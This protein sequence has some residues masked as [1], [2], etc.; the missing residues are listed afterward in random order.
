MKA[1]AK[2]REL[3]NHI[4]SGVRDQNYALVPFPLSRGDFNRGVSH[5]FEFLSL[6]DDVKNQFQSNIIE[7]DEESFVGYIKREKQKRVDEALGEYFYDQKEYFH[8]NRYAEEYFR[9]FLNRGNERITT[10]FESARLIY[11][12]AEGVAKQIINDFNEEFP[13]LREKFTPEGAHPHFYL[14]FL[15]YYTSGKGS[16]LA[17]AHYDQGGYTLAL[18][19]S[20]PGLRIGK[21]EEGLKEVEHTDRHAVFMPGLQLRFFTS[22]EFTPA[23]H[24]VVQKGDDMYNM[25]TARWAVVFFVD[26]VE[27][28]RTRWEDR[29]KAMN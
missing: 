6:P 22:D 16:F 11:E 25:E 27:K 29:H 26:P 28:I 19:E 17:K 14:R 15:K 1:H 8:Y 3:L 4:K 12:H 7:S 23:W 9:D 21:N 10:F 5:F 24:D 2:P 20:A 18:A 13:G